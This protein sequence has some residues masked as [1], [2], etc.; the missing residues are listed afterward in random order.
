MLPCIYTAQK[1][2][3]QKSWKDGYIRTGKNGC[4]FLHDHEKKV[5]TSFKQK[6]L[7]NEFQIANY[8]IY[9]EDLS[10]GELKY[11]DGNCNDKA[12]DSMTDK[13]G[14]TSELGVTIELDMKS[15]INSPLCSNKITKRK[16]LFK[17]PKQS[18]SDGNQYDDKETGVKEFKGRT[19]DEILNLIGNLYQKVNK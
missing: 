1:N 19:K 15:K 5:I 4:Y 8:L 13:L 7:T 17:T 2:K 9:I 6:Y 12:D 3:K 11:E 16:S 14:V 18:I 10:H